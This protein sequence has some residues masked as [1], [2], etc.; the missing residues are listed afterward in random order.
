MSDATQ[1]PEI[2]PLGSYVTAAGMLRDAAH[3][4]A[5]PKRMTV[6]EAA[7]RHYVVHNPGGGT[8]GPW[9][10][11]DTPYMIKPM[12]TS[13][14]R[15]LRGNV[16]VGPAQ[17][18][19]TDGLVMGSIVY[20]ATCDP[21]DIL[22]IQTSEI[23]A[24][25]YSKRR[26]DR[27]LRH[28]PAVARTLT[29]DNVLEKLFGA[30][31]LSLGY[32]AIGQLSGRPIP[33]VI[34]TDRDRMA[35]N[36]DG[37]GDPF[38]L[39]M[40]RGTAFF[41]R[42]MTIAESSPGKPILKARWKPST[43]HE[44][45][46]AT[47]ILALYNRGD[48]Q[49]WHWPCPQC[50][51]YFEA[52]FRNLDWPEGLEI[53]EA[54]ERAVL[55]CP[56]HGCAIEPKHKRALNLAGVWV[57]EGQAVDGHGRL[58]GE[59]VRSDIASFWLKGPAAAFMSWGQLVQN[60]LAAL[61]EFERTGNEQALKTTANVDQAEAYLPRASQTEGTLEAEQLVERAEAYGLGRV[62]EGAR[63][64]TAAVDVQ[65]TAFKV[66]VRA[67]GV[68]L[69]S[70]VVDSFAIFKMG[71]GEAE[72]PVNP[73]TRGEDWDLIFDQVAARTYP[74]QNGA[75][76]LGILRVMVDSGGA[77]GVTKQA[78]DF[79]RR[80]RKRGLARRVILGKGEP[81][82][83]APRVALGYPDSKRKD[84]KAGGRGEV[85]VWFFNANLL[86]DEIDAALRKE[87]PGPLYLHL[88]RELLD[89]REPH[90]FFEELTA[91]ERRPDGK[92][93]KAKRTN[94]AFDLAVM[95]LAAALSVRAD[96]IDWANPPPWASAPDSN[97][98]A[99]PADGADPAPAAPARPAPVRSQRFARRTL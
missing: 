2:A 16:F 44:A 21:G 60:H 6:S 28:S 58:T 12:N 95:T 41:S 78:Y 3:H 52:S 18:G 20:R 39:G 80:A 77:P 73:A 8:S 45:P 53:A 57:P 68:G 83:N 69:E 40:K 25:D 22:L 94:D 89:E 42:A 33:W 98:L 92:W 82:T 54:A 64:L 17:S 34:L 11:D 1:L 85:P 47:G 35:D 81:R 71:Q 37:E 46:P 59:A 24:R 43:P 65:K 87:E 26:V 29:G 86:R 48:R 5:P 74:L 56:N 51:E 75:G 84:R 13:Q 32:P 93:I 88:S 36:I 61:A 79:Q 72:R 15:R 27:M 62:P 23:M 55:I 76:E 19:K 70:W 96:R 50:N 91:E 9:S 90:A 14:R 49:R 31:I 10:P 66:L 4:L 67:F 99:A 63:F 30:M 97:P 38:D 7:R